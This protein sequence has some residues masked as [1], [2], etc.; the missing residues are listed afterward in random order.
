MNSGDV[1]TIS[2]TG[3]AN[4]TE[5]ASASLYMVPLPTIPAAT[6][7]AGTTGVAYTGA[8]TETNGSGAVP[9]EPC[10]GNFAPGN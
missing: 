2:A 1:A 7:P 6:L 8:V 3:V 5:I 10:F 4:P 9:L